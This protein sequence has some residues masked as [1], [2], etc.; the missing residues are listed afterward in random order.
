[1]MQGSQ[2]IEQEIVVTMAQLIKGGRLEV[3]TQDIE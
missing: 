1:M 2:A 3:L